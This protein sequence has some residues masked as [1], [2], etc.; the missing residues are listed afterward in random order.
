MDHAMDHARSEKA[1]MLSGE[2]YRASDPTLVAERDRA[3]ALCRR[4]N[5]EPVEIGRA[6]LRELLGTDTDANIEPPFFCDYGYDI[7]IGKNFY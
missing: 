6:L 4:Y 3:K 7:R 2:L 5:D 1:R